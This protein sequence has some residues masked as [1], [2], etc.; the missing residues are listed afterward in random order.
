MRQTVEDKRFELFS[1]SPLLEEL[2]VSAKTIKLDEERPDFSFEYEGKKIGVEETKCKYRKR[3]YI[4]DNVIHAVLHDIRPILEEEG[5]SKMNLKIF[6]KEDVYLNIN[7]NEEEL[8]QEIKSLYNHQSIET[9]YIDDLI[10]EY[11]DSD[12]FRIQ[13]FLNKELKEIEPS[14]IYKSILQKEDRLEGYKHLEKNKDINEYWL[15]IRMWDNSISY[16]NQSFTEIESNYDRIYL[17]SHHEPI[18]RIK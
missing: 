16:I 5:A 18:L 1:I 14:I 10:V 12:Y 4:N 7:F 8:K 11:V 9:K 13:M 3:Y 6:F 17:V 15:V 2:G